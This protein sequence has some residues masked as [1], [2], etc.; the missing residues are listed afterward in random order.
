ML[1]NLKEFTSFQSVSLLFPVIHK[2]PSEMKNVRALDLPKM[3]SQEFRNIGLCAGFSVIAAIDPVDINAL[4]VRRVWGLLIFLN[5][6]MRLPKKERE[7]IPDNYIK[8]ASKTLMEAW[9]KAFGIRS[10]VYN[11]HV[12]ISHALEVCNLGNWW[13]SE[14]KL[15]F[16][17]SIC[18]YDTGTKMA[19]HSNLLTFSRVH[20]LK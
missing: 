19:Q 3:K 16:P 18:S 13:E 11:V 8:S 5:R 20:I 12:A 2:W 7:I 10:C 15:G 14:W 4:R 6:S 9:I 1:L 17:L